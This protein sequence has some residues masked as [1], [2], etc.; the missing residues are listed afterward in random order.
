MVY[1]MLKKNTKKI[2]LGVEIVLCIYM[3]YTIVFHQQNLMNNKRQQMKNIQQKIE[4][5]RKIADELN[6]EKERIDTDD[7]I[8]KVAR[9]KLGMI[10]R[11]EI[12]FYN[13]D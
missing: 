8:E 11:D 7:Y 3:V 2:F 9:E 6:K 1:Y 5:E 13:V 12:V 10:K 4:C